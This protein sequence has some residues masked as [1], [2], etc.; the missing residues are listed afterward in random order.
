M[1]TTAESVSPCCPCCFSCCASPW[2]AHAR[3][4]LPAH[5]HGRSQLTDEATVWLSAHRLRQLGCA[6][7]RRKMS[8]WF[9][10]G[11]HLPRSKARVR[12]PSGIG[13]GRCGCVP[14]CSILVV[15]SVG[16]RHNKPPLRGGSASGRRGQ[17]AGSAAP[18][19][20]QKI[21][22]LLGAGPDLRVTLRYMR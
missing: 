7:K 14:F 21:K 1:C 5:T 16:R 10:R 12:G 8:T 6:E 22:L 4:L 3:A 15:L 2:L 13:G 20:A 18:D 9:W 19:R 17:V 11:R